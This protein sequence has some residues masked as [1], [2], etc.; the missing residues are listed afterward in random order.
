M[1]SQGAIYLVLDVQ[2]GKDVHHFM[3]LASLLG[4]VHGVDTPFCLLFLTWQAATLGRPAATAAPL[5]PDRNPVTVTPEVAG[6]QAL[7]IQCS[8]VQVQLFILMLDD[9]E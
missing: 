8:L 2:A 4:A 9:V 5:Q 6:G 7:G 1:A 3:T